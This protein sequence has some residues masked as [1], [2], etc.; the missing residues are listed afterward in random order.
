MYKIKRAKELKG[1]RKDEKL[2]T[3]ERVHTHGNLINKKETSM[4]YAL[5]VMDRKDR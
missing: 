4:K 5:L 3:L 2:E 1:E